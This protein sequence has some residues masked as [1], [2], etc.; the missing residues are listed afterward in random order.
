MRLKINKVVIFSRIP[1]SADL[2]TLLHSL[3]QQDP[4]ALR[5]HGEPLS[6]DIGR[7][8][9]YVHVKIENA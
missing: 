2:P 5:R 1:S 4:T 7:D 6:S 8:R 3:G 9:G